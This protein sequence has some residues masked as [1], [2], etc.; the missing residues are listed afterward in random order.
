MTDNT[1]IESKR[2]LVV[3]RLDSEVK[4]GRIWWSADNA[5]E[6]AAMREKYLAAGAVDVR[7]V[8]E[9]DRPIMNYST[10][11]AAEDGVSRGR[12]LPVSASS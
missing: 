5:A 6:A 10:L 1:T 3:P 9:R 4:L 12:W 8:P 2:D 7:L 11:C